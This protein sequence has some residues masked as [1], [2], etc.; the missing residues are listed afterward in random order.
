M[1]LNEGMEAPDFE[2]TTSNGDKFRLSDYKGKFV[3][4]YFYPRALTSGCT[5]E[6]IRFNELY[7]EFKKLNAEIFGIS[8]DPIERNKKF[9]EKYGFRFPLL[10]DPDGKIIKLYKVK[11]ENTSS[12]SA[13]RTTYIIDPIRIIVK[14]LYNLRPAEKHADQSLVEVRKLLN[15]NETY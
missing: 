12:L 15:R 10:S 1:P 2:L 13:E 9:A 8:S 11:K 3:I 4:L 7:D 14:V 5:R 6:G